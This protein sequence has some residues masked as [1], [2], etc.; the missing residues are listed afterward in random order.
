MAVALV[1]ALVSDAWTADSPPTIANSL[2]MIGK[3]G[4]E[5]DDSLLSVNCSQAERGK[6]VCTIVTMS[7]L[8]PRIDASKRTQDLNA[9]AGMK[10]SKQGKES[11][12]TEC[13]EREK[14]KQGPVTGV[15]RQY[16]D[17]WRAACASG[18]AAAYWSAVR[19]WMEEVEFRTCD[20]LVTTER[21]EFTQLDEN[22]WRSSVEKIETCDATL[23]RTL[24]RKNASARW[25]YDQ[26]STMP[27]D[28]SEICKNYKRIGTTSYGPELPDP[29]ELRCR[30][31]R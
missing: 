12:K 16:D 20:L 14:E 19:S 23:I 17:R 3:V 27:P 31:W 6:A 8:Q 28:A 25:I 4:H 26:A 15:K 24:S 13:A 22:T 29:R 21:V 11:F 30:Y 7:I 10:R 1:A 18:D 5:S 2:P 9:I